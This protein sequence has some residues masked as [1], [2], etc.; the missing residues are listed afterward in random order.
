MLVGSTFDL[1]VGRLLSTENDNFDYLE[2]SESADFC[3]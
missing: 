3:L 2:R 1:N